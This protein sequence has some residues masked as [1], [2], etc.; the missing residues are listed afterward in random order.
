MHV[1]FV[2][3]V[4][5]LP[6][7]TEEEKTAAQKDREAQLLRELIELIDERDTLERKKMTTERK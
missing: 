3:M 4:C 1:Q 7:D 5:L 6:F 2:C